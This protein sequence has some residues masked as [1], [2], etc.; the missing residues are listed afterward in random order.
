M[1]TTLAVLIVA[2]NSVSFTHGAA[3]MKDIVPALSKALGVPLLV[4]PE[5]QW[6]VLYVQT[7][8]VSPNDL[9]SKVAEASGSIWDVNSEGV[10]VLKPNPAVLARKRAEA[11]EFTTEMI[12]DFLASA[13]KSKSPKIKALAQVIRSIGVQSLASFAKGTRLV[14]STHPTRMQRQTPAIS[15]ELIQ[16]MVRDHNTEANKPR[17]EP[18][19]MEEVKK[20]LPPEMVKMIEAYE[21]MEK[22]KPITTPIAKLNFV[23]SIQE[24]LSTELQAFDANGKM[25]IQSSDGLYSEGEDLAELPDMSK[26]RAKGDPT[27]AKE[28]EPKE[29]TRA[30]KLSKESA[31][32]IKGLMDYKARLQKSKPSPTKEALLKLT[33]SDPFL[34]FD[35][36]V[37][38]QVFAAEKRNIIISCPESRAFSQEQLTFG[39]VLDTLAMDTE[40][41]GPWLIRPRE[42]DDISIDTERL[43]NVLIRLNKKT[44]TLDD[45]AW[46]A[47]E[48]DAFP[49]GATRATMAIFLFGGNIYGSNS[50]LLKLYGMLSP[51]QKQAAKAKGVSISSLDSRQK[52]FVEKMV[53]GIDPSAKAG[54]MNSNYGANMFEDIFDMDTMFKKEMERLEA[55]KSYLAEPTEALPNGL[56]NDGLVT[57]SEVLEP[58]YRPVSKGEKATPEDDVLGLGESVSEKQL[59]SLLAIKEM[60]MML[61]EF[62]ATFPKE[63]EKIQRKKVELKLTCMPNYGA[64]EQMYEATEDAA[65]PVDLTKMGADFDA[66]LDKMKKSM[67]S[68]E[69]MMM[70]GGGMFSGGRKNPPP[71]Y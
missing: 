43:C 44:L 71:R 21:A 23:F 48:Y 29:D 32:F 40:Q 28:A 3:P 57:L 53:Y 12:N 70:L 8:D 41:K 36:E 13:I 16:A 25:V 54:F 49:R 20:S 50:D 35:T 31:E 47:S 30:I 46:L 6:K 5:E 34:K 59:A 55:S 66:T 37:Y 38:S 58:G 14:Y 9:L 67:K 11:K 22:P 63:F 62:G 2:Q 26:P 61:G 45:K 10:R 69:K 18:D 17:E 19:D 7:K 56:P 42:D 27:E 24:Y 1:L 4:S 64:M 51:S 33:E 52:A 60:P 15:N 65:Q 39:N 68:M